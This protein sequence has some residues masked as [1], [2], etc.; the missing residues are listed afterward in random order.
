[1]TSLPT[2]DPRVDIQQR[3]E[4]AWNYNRW[5]AAQAR[6]ALGRR[7]LDAGCGSG[8]VTD[9]ILDRDLIVAVDVWKE[10]VDIVREKYAGLPHVHV[11]RYDL[12]DPAI[13]SGLKDQNL[14]S[15]LCVNVLEHVEDHAGALRNIATLLPAGGRLFLLVPAFPSIYGRMDAADHH[16]R[17][18]TKKSLRDT[19]EPLPWAIESLR[20]MNLPGYFA[21]ALMG[22]LLRKS[23]LDESTYGIY[24]RIIPLL[25]AV[26]ERVAP[27]FGQSL[28]AVLRRT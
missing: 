11:H 7:V 18:Y 1:M 16:F 6:E 28:V 17:R 5:I 23:L 21:W 9:L 4:R 27:P 12:A 15:A 13:V 20:Y 22:K 24:D 14:D 19:V 3:L 25:R 26:E 2:G 10:F 8:N